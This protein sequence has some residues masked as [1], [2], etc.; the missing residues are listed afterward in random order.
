MPGRDYQVTEGVMMNTNHPTSM[1]RF[2]AIRSAG[3]VLDFVRELPSGPAL[4]TATPVAADEIGVAADACLGRCHVCSGLLDGSDVVWERFGESDARLPAHAGC[5]EVRAGLSAAS[6]RI[7]IHIGNWILRSAR[8]D[9]H[10]SWRP[11][12]LDAWAVDCGTAIPRHLMHGT[13]PGWTAGSAING[14]VDFSRLNR[15]LFIHER[16][17]VKWSARGVS[18]PLWTPDEDWA[19]YWKSTYRPAVKGHGKKRGRTA[20]IS[21]AVEARTDGRCALCGD[22]ASADHHMGFAAD[23]ILPHDKGGGDDL[24]NLQPLHHHCNHAVWDRCAAEIVLA[25]SVGRWVVESLRREAERP[26]PTP[27]FT[28]LAQSYATSLRG[29]ADAGKRRKK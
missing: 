25:S 2:R 22:R 5:H 16:E 21:S 13:L 11:E 14:H 4:V 28:R 17:Q 15:L 18:F 3:D 10:R 1:R 6:I 8:M 12:M 29:Q 23:H 27:V 26:G 19:M 7:G 9:E 20:S 24:R